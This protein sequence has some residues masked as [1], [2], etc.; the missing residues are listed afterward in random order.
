MSGRR[1]FVVDDHDGFRATARRLLEAEGW[2]VVGETA[3]GGT[4]IETAAALRPDL[5]LLDIGLPDLD[6]FAVAE[7]LAAAGVTNIVLVSSRDRDAYGER[8]GSTAARGFITKGDLD[9]AGLRRLL[10]PGEDAP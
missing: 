5:V 7:R 2:Q 9:G 4:A 6:G 1:V 3:D 8:L 10:Q